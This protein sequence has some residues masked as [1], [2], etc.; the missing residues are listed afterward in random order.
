[1][2]RIHLPQQR[3]HG[4]AGDDLVGQARQHGFRDAAAAIA[5]LDVGMRLVDQPGIWLG[6]AGSTQQGEVAADLSPAALDRGVVLDLSR[7]QHAAAAGRRHDLGR[8]AGEVVLGDTAGEHRLPQRG[9]ACQQLRIESCGVQ[10]VL[11]VRGARGV[12]IGATAVQRE[13]AAGPELRAKT[14]GADEAVLQHDE[15]HTLRSRALRQ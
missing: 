10:E 8:G 4:R 7:H 13:G 1:M 11:E 15:V 12:V 5:G 9:R 2:H 3:V 14:G 6:R